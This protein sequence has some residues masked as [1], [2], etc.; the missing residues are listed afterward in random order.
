MEP[1]L[2]NPII[3][4]HLPNNYH[5]GNKKALFYNLKLYYNLVNEDP[6]DYIPLTFHIRN[7]FK[8]EEYKRFVTYYNRRNNKI[9]K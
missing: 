8:D 2:E 9:K 7:G 4:N 3:H 1:I 5:L 6:F